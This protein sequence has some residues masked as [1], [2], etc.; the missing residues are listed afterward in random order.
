[1]KCSQHACFGTWAALTLQ[2]LG[3]AGQARAA[4]VTGEN[5]RNVFS[6]LLIERQIS[7]APCFLG[8]LMS[9]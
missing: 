8:V 2:Q 1:M 3:R 9:S 4:I 5:L 7:V 6:R